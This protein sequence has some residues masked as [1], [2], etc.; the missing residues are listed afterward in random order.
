MTISRPRPDILI[1]SLEDEP[2]AAIEVKNRQNLS[3]DVATELRQNLLEFGLQ[4]QAP[5][6]LLLSQDVGYLWK[7]SDQQS[8]LAPPDYEFSMD[9]VITRSIVNTSGVL[10]TA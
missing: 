7:N 6:F 10:E 1:K 5:Y 8:P 9:N 2:I 4:S 3:K